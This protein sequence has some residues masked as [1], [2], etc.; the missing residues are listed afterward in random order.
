MDK[1]Y[2]NEALGQRAEYGSGRVEVGSAEGFGFT[3]STCM[4]GEGHDVVSNKYLHA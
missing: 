4:Q 1:E 3:S 2:G